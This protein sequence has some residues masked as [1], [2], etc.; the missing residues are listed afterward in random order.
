MFRSSQVPYLVSAN[1]RQI[2]GDHYKKTAGPCP[3]CDH[4]LEHWDITWAFRFDQ[5]QYCISKY[6]WRKKGP[7]GRPL[8]ADLEKAKHHLEKYIEVTQMEED[9]ALHADPSEATPD[10]VDQ[11]R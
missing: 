9:K 7:G 6:I 4:P 1:E 3:H 5:F 11:D 8:L 10:Y 2:G